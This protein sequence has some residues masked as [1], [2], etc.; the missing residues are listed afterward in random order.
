MKK[1]EKIIGVG[2]L[3]LV[4]V[5]GIAYAVK[6]MKEVDNFCDDCEGDYED[7]DFL[8]DDLDDLD[9]F[10]E[11]SFSALYGLSREGCIR[12]IYDADEMYT[13]EDLE[14]MSDSD[15]YEIYEVIINDS[16]TNKNF[17]KV[18]K[19]EKDAFTLI[20]DGSREEVIAVLLEAYK[21][22]TSFRYTKE[23]LEAM[24]DAELT[25]VNADYKVGKSTI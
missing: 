19:E 25:A 4:V 15:L 21:D 14:S 1:V 20:N 22:D 3:S 5:G 9:D 10:K 7:D 11:D 24:S 2:L 18:V 17:D 12:I 13:V 6:K 23:D 8:E 16:E